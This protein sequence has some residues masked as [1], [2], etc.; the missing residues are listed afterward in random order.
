MDIIPVLPLSQGEID[1]VSETFVARLL[2]GAGIEMASP[3]ALTNRDEYAQRSTSGGMPVAGS[4]AHPGT[5]RLGASMGP[6]L[7]RA[8][9]GSGS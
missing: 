5:R 7:R 6:H 3:L 2:D 8:G 1:N 9:A 4:R